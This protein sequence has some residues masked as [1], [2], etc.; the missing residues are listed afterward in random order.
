MIRR[1]PCIL[2][3]LCPGALPSNGLSPPSKQLSILDT[4]SKLSC[5][6]A[7]NGTLKDNPCGGQSLGKTH[8]NLFLTFGGTGPEKQTLHWRGTGVI[9]TPFTRR[10]PAL[11][12]PGNFARASIQR[13]TSHPCRCIRVPTLSRC[14]LQ[15]STPTLIST[16]QI[17]ANFTSHPRMP[18]AT[19][20]RAVAPNHCPFLAVKTCS[21]NSNPMRPPPLSQ[22][23]SQ[24]F[25]NV[26]PVCTVIWTRNEL[27]S[28]VLCSQQSFTPPSSP[29][30][31]F[32]VSGSPL[33]Y[34]TTLLLRNTPAPT[35]KTPSLTPSLDATFTDGLEQAL[36]NP[37]TMSQ[38]SL[39]PYVGQFPLHIHRLLLSLFS[40]FLTSLLNPA[41]AASSAILL[42]T[43]SVHSTC[44]K[45]PP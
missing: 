20:Q 5:K 8:G 29:L 24:T 6:P 9:P 39:E 33:L 19:H 12:T 11:A 21:G 38:P 13:L 2:A 17:P 1:V 4:R 26:T 28:I 15:K 7:L 3:A 42:S 14:Q 18:T 35:Q 31:T 36:L 10:C 30:S 40:S 32:K 45:P 23:Q 37:I 34:S 16:L 44:P 27:C 43:P 22:K 25:C 41:S